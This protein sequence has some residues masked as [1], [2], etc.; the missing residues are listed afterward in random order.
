[1]ATFVFPIMGGLSVADVDTALVLRV[2][3]Q[4]VEGEKGKRI[5]LWNARSETASRLRG[6]I[7]STLNWAKARGMRTGENPAQWRGHLDQLL[8]VRSKVRGVQHHPALPYGE[9][10]DFIEKLRS[11][12]GIASRALEF[13]VLTVS[14]TNEALGA[15]FDEFDLGAKL[16]TVPSVRM[17]TGREHRVPL[18]TRAVAIVKDMAAIRQSDFV[19]LGAKQGQPLSQ[20]SLLMLLHHLH[21]TLR[22]TGFA[23]L[24]KIG[25]RNART[26]LIS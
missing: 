7:E 3:Q 26:H 16:W 19:F 10:P 24:S 23:Q 17:K 2:L 5:P 9:L 18:S 1:L 4:P 25:V 6:R 22:H 8:P 11:R 14:R 21:L 20:K 13:T 12:S 15:H